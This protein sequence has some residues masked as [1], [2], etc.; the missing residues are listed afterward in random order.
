MNG[1]NVVSFPGKI[2]NL[3]DVYGQEF[4]ETLVSPVVIKPES[5]RNWKERVKW[6]DILQTWVT[7]WI[8]KKGKEGNP[9]K[10]IGIISQK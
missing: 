7:E 6:K 2:K 10:G 5:N 4:K 8:C 3:V 1:L 9:I